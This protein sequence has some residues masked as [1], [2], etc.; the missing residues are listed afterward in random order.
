M[1]Y[2]KFQINKAKQKNMRVSGYMLLKFRI[3]RSDYF[4]FFE[5]ILDL[6]EVVFIKTELIIFSLSRDVM[7]RC[8]L[9][10]IG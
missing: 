7:A 10:F 9:I 1:S 2:L 4:L 3:G 6:P 8:C 5:I